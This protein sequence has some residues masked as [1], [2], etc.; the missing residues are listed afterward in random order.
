MKLNLEFND[1]EVSTY[2]KQRKSRPK[3]R[4][5]KILVPLK[6]SIPIEAQ[7]Q[8]PENAVIILIGEFRNGGHL[9]GGGWY[10]GNYYEPYSITA[11]FETG[12][13]LF[14]IPDYGQAMISALILSKAESKKFRLKK[15]VRK[16][17]GLKTNS[18]LILVRPFAI[19]GYDAGVEKTEK[20]TSHTVDYAHEG[21][22][23]Y[24]NLRSVWK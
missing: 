17:E 24:K 11:S 5:G 23:Y 16:P 10:G 2:E 13:A 1:T 21:C 4:K 12:K 3:K 6:W 22:P 20:E 9:R 18:D 8:L 19:A 15:A 7:S 14:P